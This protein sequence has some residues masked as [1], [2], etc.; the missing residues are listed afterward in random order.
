MSQ[1]RRYSNPQRPAS[2]GQGSARPQSAEPRS[3]FGSPTAERPRTA[4]PRPQ[5]GYAQRRPA[6]PTR[7]GAPASVND[8]VNVGTRRFRS[9]IIKVIGGGVAAVL[10]ALLLQFAWPDGF[11]VSSSQKVTGAVKQI[12][13]IYSSGP[14]RINEIMTANRYTLLNSD[15]ESADWIEI[16]N[17]SDGKVD[18][19]GWE[20]SK[21]ANSA[22][23]FTFPS[24]TLAP[25]E[26]VLVCA[27]SRL[28]ETA[29]EELHAPFRISSGG[30]TLMLFNATGTAVDTVNIPA[31]N[32]DESYVR[33]STTD[34]EKSSTPTPGLENTEAA[35]AQ[36]KTDSVDSPIVLTEIMPSNAKSLMDENG[37]YNDYIKLCNRS[38]VAVSLSG[39]Y[40]S[41]DDVNPR[42]W[43]FPDVTMEPGETLTVFA[44]GLDKKEDSKH[45]HTNFG[46]SSEGEQVIL[47]D[48]HGRRMS[49][50]SFGLLKADTAWV[51]SA[52]GTWN[53]GA[54]G[55]GIAN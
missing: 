20:L 46:L 55:T 7:V 19:G 49:S 40:L 4:Q 35:Y 26:C 1:T 8:A 54:A 17:V 28:R 15:G 50:T 23:V 24:M 43:R 31:L 38:N 3:R 53:T 34:W 6:Q 30:D 42:K 37:Q 47:S 41:D 13:E 33:K 21:T 44:S 29:G 22:A 36:M 10:L 45:L 2:S 18:L 12:N 9:D 5:Q 51:R 39:W 11:P 27:D 16:A 52:G 25:N 32:R 14:L 48:A